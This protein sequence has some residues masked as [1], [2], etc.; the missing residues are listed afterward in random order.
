[1]DG[2]FGRIKSQTAMVPK[3]SRAAC[4]TKFQDQSSKLKKKYCFAKIRRDLRRP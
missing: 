2:A 4:G 1:M 3:C